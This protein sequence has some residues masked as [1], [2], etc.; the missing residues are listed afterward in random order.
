MA[1]IVLPRIWVARAGSPRPPDSSQ[2][3]WPTGGSAARFGCG[4]C[5]SIV[6]RTSLRNSHASSSATEGPLPPQ[7]RRHLAYRAVSVSRFETGVGAEVQHRVADAASTGHRSPHRNLHRPVVPVRRPA[8]SA[9]NA[10]WTVTNRW[11]RPSLRAAAPPLTVEQALAHW[12]AIR[13][14]DG[15][16]DRSRR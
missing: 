15:E 1:R 2:R 5:V 11:R 14:F 16:P 10:A 7:M 9:V 3:G 8:R 12:R 4:R 6:G 13:R